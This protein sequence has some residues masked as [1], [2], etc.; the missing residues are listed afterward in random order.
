MRKSI[1]LWAL[2]LV[3]SVM[4]QAQGASG[5]QKLKRSKP[6]AQLEELNRRFS[7]AVQRK[8]VKA[9]VQFYASDA[10]L[11]APNAPMSTGHAQIE[12]TWSGVLAAGLADLKLNTE[13]VERQGSVLIEIGTYSANFGNKPDKGKYAV[14]WKK[15][16]GEWK[17]WLDSFSSDL[18]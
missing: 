6:H 11:L 8:D 17:L 15:Q 1:W 2:L 5:G 12:K 14:I 16:K 9:I 3:V 18:P 13:T 4:A 10:R 7:E